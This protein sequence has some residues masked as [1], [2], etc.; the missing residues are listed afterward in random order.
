MNPQEITFKRFHDLYMESYIELEQ[1]RFFAFHGVMP[2]E[3]VVGNDFEVNLRV[4]TDF[5]A[6]IRRDE[7]DNTISYADLYEV[8]KR[9]M[10]R[11][12]ALIEHVAGRILKAI[13][14]R[15]SAIEEVELKVSKLNPP[16]PGEIGRASVVIRWRR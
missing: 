12:S 5:I 4:K 14:A 2:Q 11:P 8:V 9:E 10:M 3:R 15:W 6:A 13:T 1:M 16:I 7:L